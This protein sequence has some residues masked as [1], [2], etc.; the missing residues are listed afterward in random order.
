[1]KFPN[2]VILLPVPRF[3]WFSAGIPNF[4]GAARNQFEAQNV[5]VDVRKWASSLHQADFNVM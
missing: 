2:S 3:C 4:S 5:F 1:M